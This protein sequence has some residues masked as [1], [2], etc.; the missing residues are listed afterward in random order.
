MLFI[1]KFYFNSMLQCNY[2]EKEVHIG[3]LTAVVLTVS[4][5]SLAWIVGQREQQREK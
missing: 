3:M 5:L 2:K 4:I 1:L